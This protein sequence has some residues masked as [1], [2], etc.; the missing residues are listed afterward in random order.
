MG[1][2][3]SHPFRDETA[4]WME[5]PGYLGGAVGARWIAG[6]CSRFS[7]EVIRGLERS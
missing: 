5:Y 4:E 1:F 7:E 2:V 6:L 3:D